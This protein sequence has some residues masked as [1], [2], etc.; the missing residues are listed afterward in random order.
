[1]AAAKRRK[2]AATRAKKV[3]GAARRTAAKKPSAKKTAVKPTASISVLIREKNI[4]VSRLHL[5]KSSVTPRHRHDHPYIVHPL[6]AG[7]VRRITYMGDKVV[8]IERIT[9][10]PDRPYHVPATPPG[11]E[12]VIENLGGVTIADKFIC[13][14]PGD[15]KAP[16]TDDKQG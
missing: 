13:M 10:K 14:C 3:G 5:P 2:S 11:C 4:I 1:M 15:Y 8:K 7:R 6:K 9:F 16:P 12:F